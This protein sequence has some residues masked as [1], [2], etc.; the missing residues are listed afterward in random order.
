ML[1]LLLLLLILGE[2]EEDEE[3]DECPF[4]AAVELLLLLEI[5]GGTKIALPVEEEEDGD[6]VKEMFTSEVLGLKT[7][8]YRAVITPAM[9]QAVMTPATIKLG[10]WAFQTALRTDLDF[11]GIDVFILD[12]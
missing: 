6:C 12:S 5:E 9:P 11:F 7:K 3:E 8:K 4:G 2:L 10:L 1:L